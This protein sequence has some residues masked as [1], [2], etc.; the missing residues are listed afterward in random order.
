MLAGENFRNSEIGY[1]KVTITGYQEILGLDI[2]MSDPVIVQIGNTPKQLLEAAQF[3][4]LF[5]EGF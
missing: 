2:P 4:G 1:L 3:L 5:H